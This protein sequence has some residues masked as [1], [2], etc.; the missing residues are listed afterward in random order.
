MS[1]HFVDEKYLGTRFNPF[2]LIWSVI[3]Q[4]RHPCLV[5][6]W[7]GVSDLAPKRSVWPR[8]RQIQDFLRS[9]VSSF[10]L[11]EP[12]YIEICS[13]KVMDLSHLLPIW[14]HFEPR[15]DHLVSDLHCPVVCVSIWHLSSLWGSSV[16]PLTSDILCV[17]I[18]LHFDLVRTEVNS[19]SLLECTH[20]VS[21]FSL[22]RN[23]SPP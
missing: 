23:V 18:W 9:N 2:V 14:T 5:F 20:G 19:T 21:S 7:Q 10:W 17:F 8:F 3:V 15:S 11:T 6:G 16:Y 1:V 13:E 12:K 4:T 22:Q